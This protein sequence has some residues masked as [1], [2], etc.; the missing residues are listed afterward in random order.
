MASNWLVSCLVGLNIDWDCLVPHSIMGSRNKWEFPPF[1]WP[2][3]QSSCTA[4][5][6]GKCLPLGLCKGTVKQST[7]LQYTRPSPCW[8]N[9]PGNPDGA[10]LSTEHSIACWLLHLDQYTFPISTTYSD[11]PRMCNWGEDICLVLT[12]VVGSVVQDQQ[13]SSQT[14]TKRKS[15]RMALTILVLCL[16][17]V[18]QCHTR[19]NLNTISAIYDGLLLFIHPVR[20]IWWIGSLRYHT[21]DMQNN[22]RAC[23]WWHAPCW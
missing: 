18:P 10:W 11:G 2:Q 14:Q 6:A 19:S 21:L 22:A 1:F 12:S 7:N 17:D 3:W 9:N 16:P 4:P 23:L 5:T 15:V 20:S 13:L 8:A